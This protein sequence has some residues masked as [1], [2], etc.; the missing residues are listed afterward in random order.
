VNLARSLIVAGALAGLAW[1]AP[2][3]AQTPPTEADKAAAQALFDV[4]RQLTGAKRWTEACPKLEESQRLDPSLGT[5][6]YLADCFEQIG[7]LAAAQVHFYEVAAKARAAGQPDR[8]DFAKK[9]GDALGPRIPKLIVTVSD[10][11]KGT[12]GLAITRDGAVV[13]EVQLGVPILV[14]LGKHTVVATGEGG[15]RWD[16]TV[17]ITKEG[18]TVTVT[19]Q[20]LMATV[21][22]APPPAARVVPVA[23]EPPRG[24]SPVRVAGFVVGGAGLV[25]LGV[26]A[27]FGAIAMSKNSA[28]KADGH[29]DAQNLCDATGKAARL[30]AIHAATVST[31]GF[32]AGGVALAGGVVMVIV[33]KPA[34]PVN[35]AIDIGPGSVSLKGRW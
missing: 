13:S 22:A 1:P 3:R 7:R 11:A 20:G 4:A 28:S 34:A 15:K 29:C 12:P 14:E 2:A 23:P 6:Y 24:P 31:A 9:R 10:A 18:E 16:T 8:A 26:G 33:G 5:E 25:G 35:A 19:V 27:A 30:D 32:I 17:N 21:G